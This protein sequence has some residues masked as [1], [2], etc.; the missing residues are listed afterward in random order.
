MNEEAPPRTARQVLPTGRVLQLNRLAIGVVAVVALVFT[1]S[2]MAKSHGA[3]ID[4]SP[5]SFSLS[6]ATC[7][8]LPA[9][10]TVNGSGPEKSITVDKQR[11]GVETTINT[12]HAHGHA[13]DQDGNAY[14]FNYSNHFRASNT[15]ADPEVF[16]GKMVD[17]FSLAGRGP[18]KLHNG[19]LARFTTDF[20]TFF[21]LQ[22]I[23]SRGDPISFP[24]GAAHCDPL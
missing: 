7:P 20:A 5:V 17:S 18:A 4:R 13:T 14:V 23:Q 9:G 3:T 2:A 22:P 16:S 15:T 21:N 12:T 19:F 1:G 6:S 11:N 8:N 10:T 24:D